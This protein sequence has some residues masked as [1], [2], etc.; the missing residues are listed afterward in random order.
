MKTKHLVT[1]SLSAILLVGFLSLAFAGPRYGGGSG[2]MGGGFGGGCGWALQLSEED[3]AKLNTIMESHR[4]EMEPLF[5]DMQVKHEELET[6][7]QADPVDQSAVNAKVE[8]I[9][10]IRTTMMKDRLELRSELKAAGLDLPE[11]GKGRRGGGGYHGRGGGCGDCPGSDYSA[12]T[13]IGS[14]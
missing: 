11:R 14:N 4:A 3:R 2:G 10:A 1:L 13:G 12:D 7:L 5:E 8:E 9:G 6:L